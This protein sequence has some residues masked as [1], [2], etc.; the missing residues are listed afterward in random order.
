MGD[1]RRGEIVEIDFENG[2]GTIIDENGQ[3]IQFQ[4][5]EISGQVNLNAKV[6]FDIDLGLSGLVAVKVEYENI[7]VP[8]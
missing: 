1:K 3:D 2:L 4:L 7:K 6:F 8:G 5:D